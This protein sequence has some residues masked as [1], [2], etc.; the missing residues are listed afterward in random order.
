MKVFL[1]SCF[2]IYLNTMTSENRRLLEELFKKLLGEQLFINMLVVDEVLY[3][4]RK[5]GVAYDVTLDFLKSIILPYTEVVPVDEE[6]FK[7]IGK[8][9]VKYNL[10]PSDAI[11]LATMEKVGVGSIVSEDED[12]DKVKEVKRIWLSTDSAF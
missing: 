5:Y 3:M 1:D 12:F 11:H 2:L 6:D 10:K 9:L 8:Y 4:S 7:P